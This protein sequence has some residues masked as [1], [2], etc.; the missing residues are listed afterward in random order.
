MFVRKKSGPGFQKADGSTLVAVMRRT[1]DK[2]SDFAKRHGVPRFYDN[3][4]ELIDDK[5]VNA[6][7]I[8]TPPGTHLDLA[9]LCAAAGKPTY[10]E[11]PLARNSKESEMIAEAF[12]RANVPLFCAYYRRGQQR[13]IKAKEMIKN[14]QLGK[15]QNVS[16]KL[17]KPKFTE[18]TIPWRFEPLHSGGGLIMDVGCHVLDIVDYVVGPIEFMSSRCNRLNDAPYKVEDFVHIVFKIDSATGTAEFSFDGCEEQDEIQIIG[19]EGK[20]KFSTFTNDPVEFTDAEK[21]EHKFYFDPYEHV[22]QPLIQM[23]VNELRGVGPSSP[24]KADNAIRTAKVLDNALESY[25]GTRQNGFW[26]N[27]DSWPGAVE[28][29]QNN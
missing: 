12:V 26:Q 6:I 2:A 11:K 22:Q 28:S 13:F 4:Q 23:I 10:I 3:A 15:I 17:S 8:A 19:T 14:G 7:Y 29:L 25:Y 27:S 1:L 18:K 24:S 9:L 20:L 21:A 16:I 5:D